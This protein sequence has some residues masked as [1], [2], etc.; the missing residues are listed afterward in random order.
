MVAVCEIAKRRVREPRDI[1]LLMTREWWYPPGLGRLVKQPVTRWFFS[2]IAKT[3][4]FIPLPPVVGLDEM[5]GQGALGVRQALALT[6]GESPQLV[7]VAPEGRTGEQGALCRPPAGA[8]LFL[9]LL[10]HGTIPILPVG[11]SE[12]EDFVLTVSFGEPFQLRVSRELPREE[13]D[14][15]AAC[16]VMTAIGKQLPEQMW[17]EYRRQL[18]RSTSGSP[19]NC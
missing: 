13:Q 17:G 18:L 16:Q 10:T 7:G 3:Y 2:R 15:D 8:G 14:R 12:S 9:V 5:R 19:T 4:G 6:R 1:R 11:I